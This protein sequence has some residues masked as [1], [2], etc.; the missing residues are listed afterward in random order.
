MNSD[1][2]WQ[3]VTC[4]LGVMFAMVVAIEP[5]IVVLMNQ[6]LLLSVALIEIIITPSD[7]RFKRGAIVISY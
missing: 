7:R 6:T 4:L 5:P 3:H 2:I 1:H